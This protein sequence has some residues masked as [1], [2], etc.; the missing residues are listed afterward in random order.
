VALVAA[1]VTTYSLLR[2][3]LFRR[4]DQTLDTTAI[5][6]ERLLAEPLARVAF[7]PTRLHLGKRPPSFAPG[8][9]AALAP[10]TFVQ[11]RRA[12]GSTII[13]S[14]AQPA[15][16]PGGKS[17]TPRLPARIP[18]S[19][20][21]K[22]NGS[23][24]YFTVRST[25]AG[26]PQFRVRVA[27][28]AGR[29][30]IVAAPLG[31]TIGTLHRLLAVELVVTLIALTA[32]GLLGLWVV[33]LGLRPLRAME[34]SADAI[35]GGVFDERVAGESSRTEVGQL[36]RTLNVML[37]RI[38]GAFTERDAKEAALRD[39]EERMRHFVADASHE[40]RTP[41]A[42]VSA[43]AE[44]FDRGAERNEADL[45]R[46]IDGI[47]RESGRMGTLVE[48]LLLL[49][50]L[51]EGRPITTEPVDLV[52]LAVEA[53]QTA[54]TV[55]AAW[56]IAVEVEEPVEAL[57]ERD[58]L[59]RV[60]DNLLLNVRTH[61]PPG[62]AATITLTRQRD[63]A[64][65][66]VADDGPGFAAGQAEELFARFFRGDPSRSRA[67]GGGAGL[68]LAIV[69]AIVV[70]H[71]GRVSAHARPGGGALFTVSLPASDRGAVLAGPGGSAET[72][73]APHHASLSRDTET[74]P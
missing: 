56:P 68:G 60:L 32:A 30:L 9:L 48:E 63:L 22:D 18:V 49:A 37:E 7:G 10:G 13:P 43:Y 2:S 38:Q 19:S 34:R 61:T 11:L 23:P 53:M 46:L 50:R 70:A 4:V 64:V 8:S 55:G 14:V 39:S 20:S 44:L 15:I 71:G 45:R 57:G 35:A 51:D 67:H 74:C 72:E 59:R 42:A 47:R 41:L 66:E 16:F 5:P 31:D 27:F 52:S 36:A 28:A 69:Q 54:Q 6:I 65:I 62:T 73:Q 25:Q 21:L 58:A 33:T 26:G 12:D 3:F 24:L 29:E 40:L 1:D 17:S